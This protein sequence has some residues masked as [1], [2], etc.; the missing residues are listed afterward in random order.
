[1]QITVSIVIMQVTVSVI[2]VQVTVL[3]HNFHK[4]DCKTFK[5][6]VSGLY[7]TT[8]VNILPKLRC[9]DGRNYI[10]FGYDPPYQL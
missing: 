3:S 5:G 2:A 7:V 1:M 8:F 9:F 4:I 10:Q 6:I